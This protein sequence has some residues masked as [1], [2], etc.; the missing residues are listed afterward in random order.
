[1]STE[2]LK[3]RIKGYNMAG[4]GGLETNEMQFQ[5]TGASVTAG[6]DVVNFLLAQ[7]SITE[8]QVQRMTGPAARTIQNDGTGQMVEGQGVLQQ[9]A[10]QG[11]ITQEQIGRMASRVET[12]REAQM[13]EKPDMAKLAQGAGLKE[14]LAKANNGQGTFASNVSKGKDSGMSR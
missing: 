14:A 2:N 12:Q 13:D 7:G 10:K 8:E 11:S 9:L 5:N 3:T 6:Q 1:V 4:L